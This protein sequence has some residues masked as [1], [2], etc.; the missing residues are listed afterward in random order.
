MDP[1][2]NINGE[3][4]SEKNITGK[5]ATIQDSMAP[6]RRVK[7][8]GLVGDILLHLLHVMTIAQINA[9]ILQARDGQGIE[10]VVELIDTS[11]NNWRAIQYDA[12]LEPDW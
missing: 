11:V 4:L 6:I 2:K 9:Y 8:Q 12:C 7:S 10:K 1:K 5:Q 3:N